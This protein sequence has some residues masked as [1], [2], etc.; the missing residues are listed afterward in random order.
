M[1]TSILNKGELN[2]EKDLIRYENVCWKQITESIFGDQPIHHFIEFVEKQKLWPLILVRSV[3]KRKPIIQFNTNH[4]FLPS[5]H[6]Y[7]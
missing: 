4:E 5:S 1:T 7:E 3:E 6:R 2:F